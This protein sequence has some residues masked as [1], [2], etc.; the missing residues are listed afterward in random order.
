VI[1]NSADAAAAQVDVYI[2]GAL[3]VDNFAFRTATP[4]IDV[5][6]EVALSVAIAP[7]TSTSVADAIATFPYNLEANETYVIVANG[8]VSATGYSPATPFNLYVN[9]MGRE[10]A[11]VSTNS[12]LLVFHGATDAPVVDVLAL[13]A[14]TIVN[15]L[16]Y[17]DFDGYLELPTANYALDVAA[18]AGTPVVASYL[19]PLTD[20]SLDGEAMVVVASGFLDPS[21]NSNGAAFGLWVALPAGGALVELPNITGVSENNQMVSSLFP[22]PANEFLNVSLSETTDVRAE[23]MDASGRLVLSANMESTQNMVLD[24]RSLNNGFYTLRV[25]R[26]QQAETLQFVV[27]H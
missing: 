25:I 20:L 4:F 15:D 12:D 21:M 23:V 17:G 16:A 18:A 14:G 9:A 26:N 1:H 22:V 8:I 13:G 11:T 27:K 3:A 5:P 6:A 7:S 19:A 24:V 2:N 10:A